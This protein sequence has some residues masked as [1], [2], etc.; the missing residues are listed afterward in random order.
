M[1][2]LFA[3]ELE[4]TGTTVAHIIAT[5]RLRDAGMEV[6]Y[7]PACMKKRQK[8]VVNTALQEDVDAIRHL[9]TTACD[10]FPK[11]FKG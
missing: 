5:S 7:I 11:Y 3:Q 9:H 10:R 6:I 1:E 8:M 2:F 4:Q